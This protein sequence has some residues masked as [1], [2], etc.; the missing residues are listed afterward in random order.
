LNNAILFLLFA[1]SSSLPFDF[2][3]RKRETI[4]MNWSFLVLEMTTFSL[5]KKNYSQLMVPRKLDYLSEPL[6][7]LGT[8]G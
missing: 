5:Y 3:T 1:I 4:R 8:V 6:S 2:W 7:L